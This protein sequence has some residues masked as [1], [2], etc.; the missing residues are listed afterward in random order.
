MEEL[1]LTNQKV[2]VLLYRQGSEY[3]S[4]PPNEGGLSTAAKGRRP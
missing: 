2:A 3:E 1:A 4:L